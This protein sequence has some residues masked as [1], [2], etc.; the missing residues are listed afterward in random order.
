VKVY[1]S[2]VID[3]LSGAT[4]FE[5]SF[6][7]S[8]DIVECKG[9]SSGGSNT[10]AETPA[11]IELSLVTKEQWNRFKKNYQP[12]FYKLKDDIEA[13]GANEKNVV[14]GMVN[15][16]I[17]KKFDQ[18]GSQVADNAIAKGVGPSAITLGDVGRAKEATLMPSTLNANMKVDSTKI[19]GL[20]NLVNMSRGDAGQSMQGL[21]AIAGDQVSTALRD[22]AYN[23]DQSNDDAES[24]G[25]LAGMGA[26][27]YYN[28]DK[29]KA[30]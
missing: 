10:V 25:S 17:T 15:A 29:F 1:N 30:K 12:L 9:E 21:G 20:Q 24:L 26:S 22:T 16:G 3:M 19:A 18:I 5:D 6:E 7:H 11:E 23:Q 14:G 28:R 2:V 8:D 4:I 13:I 27:L